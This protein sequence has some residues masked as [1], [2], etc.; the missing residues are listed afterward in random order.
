M[1]AG[2]L[3]ALIP[4]KEIID[5]FFNHRRSRISWFEPGKLSGS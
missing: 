1:K 5:E 4:V 3:K 2:A